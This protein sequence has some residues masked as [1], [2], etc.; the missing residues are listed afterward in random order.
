MRLFNA[1]SLAALASA[2][3]APAAF[4]ADLITVPTSTMPDAVPVYDE[5]GFDWNG[6][7]GGLYGVVQ[8]SPAGGTQYGPGAMLGV[9]TQFDFYL[10]GAE[11]AVEGLTGGTGST[12]YGQI[13]GGPASW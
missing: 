10:L 12:S 13:L 5:A 1:I 4:A 3:L 8:S 11:V 9:N 6:F 7:Y 2:T